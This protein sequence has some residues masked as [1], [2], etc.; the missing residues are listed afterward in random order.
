MIHA[1]EK[2]WMRDMSTVF[3][4]LIVLS[5]RRGRFIVG[6]RFFLFQRSQ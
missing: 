6:L 3:T 5:E 2:S 4:V 1:R